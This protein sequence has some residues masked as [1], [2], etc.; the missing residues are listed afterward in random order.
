MNWIQE[1][2]LTSGGVV[3]L[4][5]GLIFSMVF[6][7]SWRVGQKGTNIWRR[8]RTSTH[9]QK[10]IELEIAMKGSDFGAHAAGYLFATL[11]AQVILWP[12]VSAMWDNLGI[13][14]THRPRHWQSKALGIVERTLYVVSLQIGQPEFIG[15]WLVLKVAGQWRRW[16]EQWELDL[17]G[18]TKVTVVGREVFNVF[19]LGNAVSIAY[20]VV[21]TKLIEFLIKRD[22]FLALAVSVALLIGSVLLLWYTKSQGTPRATTDGSGAHEKSDTV[23]RR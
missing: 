6:L 8:G 12:L 17:G 5:R 1:F 13:P 4:V 11:V 23:A 22:W 3:A 20:A 7:V 21:G 2:L 15:V 18:G 16:T 9:P 14:L 10:K 19:L